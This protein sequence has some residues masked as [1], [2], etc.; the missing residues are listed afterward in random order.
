LRDNYSKTVWK[1]YVIPP[2]D[3]RVMIDK[4]ENLYQ[5]SAVLFDL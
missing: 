4:H 1:I 3:Q 2:G 5:I